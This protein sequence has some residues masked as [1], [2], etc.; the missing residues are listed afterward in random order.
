M[1]EHERKYF[2]FPQVLDI[3]GKQGSLRSRDNK[4]VVELHK[5]SK[6]LLKCRQVCKTWDK[7][8][9]NYI[10]LHPKHFNVDITT[11]GPEFDEAACV[12]FQ[13][14]QT[15]AF[16]RTFQASHCSPDRNP[17]V[18]RHVAIDDC[19]PSETSDSDTSDS[20]DDDNENEIFLRCVT[21][22]L[23]KFGV[24]IYH[25]TIRFKTQV[26]SST[27]YQLLQDW[28]S[29]T[30]NLRTFR[31]SFHARHN[32][33]ENPYAQKKNHRAWDMELSPMP[34]LEHLMFLKV[35]NV[36]APIFKEFV[37]KNAQIE[38]LHVSVLDRWP[39]RPDIY[40]RR[41]MFNNLQECAIDVRSQEDI[42]QLKSFV[43]G[44]TYPVKGLRINCITG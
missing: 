30:V 29:L 43:V 19:A 11:D 7:M 38:K 42:Y 9:Q 18:S 40:F 25:L 13:E 3:L 35:R 36:P 20:E 44:K 8:I 15:Q 22:V 17:F 6:P 5:I 31:L 23:E 26:Y 34:T 21:R 27:V 4:G 41:L 10:Q 12:F 37:G 1:L 28:L 33:V 14:R 32:R 16:L 39:A 24:H 2:L